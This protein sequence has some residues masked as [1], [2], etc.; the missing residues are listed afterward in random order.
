[1]TQIEA[2]TEL[3]YLVIFSCLNGG[4]E[5]TETHEAGQNTKTEEERGERLLQDCPGWR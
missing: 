3:L 5:L 4:P 2:F 1:M